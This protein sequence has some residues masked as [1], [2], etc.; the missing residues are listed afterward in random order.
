MIKALFL[1]PLLFFAGIACLIGGALLLPFVALLPLVLAIGAGVFALTLV[2]AV[3]GVI[4]RV[5]AALM[6]GVGGL[7]FGVFGLGMLAVGGVAVFA[8]G[9]VFLHLLLPVLLIAG[10]IWL[11]HH[12]SKAQQAPLQIQHDRG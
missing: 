12:F 4:F 3:F 2:F 11:I 5:I 8:I 10:V 6:I 9:A 7:V 1:L